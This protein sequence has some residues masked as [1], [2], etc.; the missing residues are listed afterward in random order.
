MMARFEKEAG[1]RDR[2]S[3]ESESCL[4]FPLAL[5]ILLQREVEKQ[6]GPGQVRPE[7]DILRMGCVMTITFVV[8]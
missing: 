1:E 7:R 4:S 5:G 3:S 8:E 2:D 6:T